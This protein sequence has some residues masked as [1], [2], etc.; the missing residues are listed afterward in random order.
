M[1]PQ[2]LTKAIWHLEA[3]LILLQKGSAKSGEPMRDPAHFT[4][5]GRLTR[6]GED[7]LYSLFEAGKNATEA[8]KMMGI[9]PSAS[10]ARLQ[11]WKK[12]KAKKRS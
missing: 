1:T 9:H 2:N 4:N 8:A 5:G 10:W 7:H 11:T 6:E 12:L 3:A